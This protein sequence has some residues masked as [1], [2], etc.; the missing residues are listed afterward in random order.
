MLVSSYDFFSYGALVLA[1]RGCYGVESYGG[2]N[3]RYRLR[4]T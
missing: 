3:V 4:R 1:D 2:T